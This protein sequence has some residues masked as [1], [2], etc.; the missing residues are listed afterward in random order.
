[1][2]VVLSSSL[3]TLCLLALGADVLTAMLTAVL[4]FALWRIWLLEGVAHRQAKVTG[5]IAAALHEG[6]SLNAALAR[7]AD[8]HQP[9]DGEGS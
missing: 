1:M 9:G 7:G 2:R 6:S 4:G 5:S 3:A 8:G